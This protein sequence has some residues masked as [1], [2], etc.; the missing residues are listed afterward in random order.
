MKQKGYT[1]IELIVVVV[2]L[3]LVLSLS[4]AGWTNY[5]SKETIRMETQEVVAWLRLIHTKALQGEKPADNCNTLNRYQISQTN[6]SLQA[7]PFCLDA[8][9]N[10]FSLA[11]PIQTKEI[12]NSTLS[13]GSD[14]S[15][16]SNSGMAD[17]ETTIE[18]E[19]YAG[20]LFTVIVSRS[21]RIS[22]QIN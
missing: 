19:D 5:Q 18:L 12:I 1:L 9:G 7:Q 3:G 8:D 6:N 20:N 22:W 17:P 4:L 2:I 10:E 15:F 21:G 11:S 16:D 14:F 13:L